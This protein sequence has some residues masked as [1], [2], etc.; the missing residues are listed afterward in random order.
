MFEGSAGPESS[1]DKNDAD[2]VDIIHSSAGSLGYMDP[3]GDVDFYPNNGKAHQPGCKGIL[4]EMMG[5]SL[6][7]Q[8]NLIAVYQMVYFPVFRSV[9]SWTI[10][11]IFCWIDN[12]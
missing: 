3:I 9:Q 8:C 5:M 7:Q 1:L 12:Q 11:S 4:K 2:F 10:A 6:G